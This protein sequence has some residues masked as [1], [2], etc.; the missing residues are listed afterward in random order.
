MNNLAAIAIIVLILGNAIW[1][2]VR[3]RKKGI[4]CIGCPHASQCNLDCSEKNLNS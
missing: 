3:K 4:K 2:I 1:Y